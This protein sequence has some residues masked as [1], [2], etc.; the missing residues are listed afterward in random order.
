MITDIVIAFFVAFLPVCA[1][2]WFTVGWALKSGRLEGFENRKE[3]QAS[4]K[5]MT[6]EVKERK[7]AEKLARKEAKQEEKAAKKEGR[8]YA[9]TKKSSKKTAF[10][11]SD[12]IHAKWMQ[13][14]GGFYG[15]MAFYTFVYIEILEIFDFL[16]NITL[17]EN[18][19]IG[20]LIQ[21]VVAFFINSLKNLIT[22]FV[23][24]AYWPDVLPAVN[25]WILLVAAWAGFT[26]G[27]I[28]ARTYQSRLHE[29]EMLAAQTRKRVAGRWQRFIEER[30]QKNVAEDTADT[31]ENTDKPG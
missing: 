4:L 21:L 5:A 9:G 11:I 18:F 20:P 1:L 26:V 23:W 7:K 6:D 25:G 22:A 30:R 13:F 15:S 16:A 31:D 24:F 14:G 29:P 3:F 17:P 10:S 28:L 19:G 8:A 2:T 27:G 12:L